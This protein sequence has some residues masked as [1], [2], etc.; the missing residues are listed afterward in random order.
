MPS[1]HKFRQFA[2]HDQHLSGLTVDQVPAPR[3]RPRRAAA[4]GHDALRD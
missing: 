3:Q 4:H 1:F 2:V